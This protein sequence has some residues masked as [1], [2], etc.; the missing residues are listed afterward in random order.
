MHQRAQPHLHAVRT[1]EL[2]LADQD[3]ET[4]VPVPDVVQVAGELVLLDPVDLEVAEGLA[5]EAAD[6]G[7]G[8]FGGEVGF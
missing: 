1:P 2:L 3:V 4:P 8:V 7:E 5:V 6:D